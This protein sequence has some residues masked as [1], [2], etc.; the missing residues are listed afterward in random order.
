MR[1]LQLSE[2]SPEEGV[3]LNLKI[4]KGPVGGS[5]CLR[6]DFKDVEELARTL[7]ALAGLMEDLDDFADRYEPDPPP[8][9]PESDRESAEFL[10]ELRRF[11]IA[12]LAARKS[13]E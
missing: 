2:W 9:L 10:A 5:S 8:E 7:L 4:E 13:A 12:A 11:R 1:S 3:P 6:I